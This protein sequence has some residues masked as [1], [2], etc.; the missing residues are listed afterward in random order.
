M[1]KELES[2]PDNMEI[3]VS[4]PTYIC[5]DGYVEEYAIKPVTSLYLSDESPIIKIGWE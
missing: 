5:D 3:Y 2:Y 4:I 1:I